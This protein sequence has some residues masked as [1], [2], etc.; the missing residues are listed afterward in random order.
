MCV[1]LIFLWQNYLEGLEIFMEVFGRLN[2]YTTLSPRVTGYRDCPKKPGLYSYAFNKSVSSLLSLLFLLSIDT[3]K[4]Y[5][6]WIC[7]RIWSLEIQ[8]LYEEL[9]LQQEFVSGAPN[10]IVLSQPLALRYALSPVI[11]I[12]T[13]HRDTLSFLSKVKVHNSAENRSSLHAFMVGF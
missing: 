9:K 7:K 8:K 3:I 6:S 2:Q 13:K 12:L 10:G 4:V 5:I 11:C 1:Q